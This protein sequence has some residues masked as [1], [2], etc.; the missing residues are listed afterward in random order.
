MICFVLF[1][2]FYLQPLNKVK[3]DFIYTLE[4]DHIQWI[5]REI[6]F[7]RQNIGTKVLEWVYEGKVMGYGLG[8]GLLHT[9]WD[10]LHFYLL[11]L[12]VLH[13]VLWNSGH[14]GRMGVM[15][16]GAEWESEFMDSLRIETVLLFWLI[17]LF[18][19]IFLFLELVLKVK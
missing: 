6:F 8:I 10:I 5:F 7:I 4:K 12:A 14:G 9:V 19:F 18:Y 3:I 15:G 16:L 17:V 13:W 2:V 11:N 1:W